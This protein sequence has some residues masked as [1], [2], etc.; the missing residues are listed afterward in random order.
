MQNILITGGSGLVG[1]RITVLLEK[2]DYQVAWLSRSAQ[3]GRKTFLW[4]IEKGE[5][6]PEALEWA[7]ATWLVRE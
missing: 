2:K 7:D 3:S 5:I 6:D 4:N 1:Q